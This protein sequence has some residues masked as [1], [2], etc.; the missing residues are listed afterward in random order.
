MEYKIKEYEPIMT[1][2]NKRLEEKAI[3]ERI[4][5]ILNE[6]KKY[7]SLEDFYNKNRTIDEFKKNNNMDIVL[8]HFGQKINQE[9][10]E[11]IIDSIKKLTEQKSS[12]DK[13]GIK[14]STIEDKEYITYENDDE[15]FF[16]DNSYSDKSIEEQMSDLQ[17]TSNEF[18]TS[19]TKENTKKMMEELRTNIKTELTLR[20]LT[21]INYEVLNTEQQKLFKFV[22]EYQQ[23]SIGLIR[24]DLD[25]KVMVDEE[26]NIMKIELV[27]DEFKIQNSKDKYKENNENENTINNDSKLS[28]RKL[29]KTQLFEGG[30]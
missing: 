30:K 6:S 12:F 21:E 23:N 15:A 26:N 25:E 2:P 17:K 18:Q 11:K 22:F 1:T 7:N 10:Y 9:D 24:V 3:V 29:P 19:D 28:L 27:N 8:K 16:L 5:H 4:M 14:T 13:E 20:Y